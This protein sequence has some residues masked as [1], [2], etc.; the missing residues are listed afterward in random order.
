MHHRNSYDALCCTE[1]M[2][3]NPERE[4]SLL[5]EWT[6]GRPAREAARE[7][8]IPE[9]T[10]YY[11]W[12]KFNRDPEK[13][14]RLARSLKPRKKL[15][16]KDMLL[17]SIEVEN[18]N[19]IQKNF[20][21]L[22]KQGKYPQAE[23]Y[24]RATREA[25]HF[26]NELMAKVNSVTAL[27]MANPEN[28]PLIPFV[29]R[30]MVG[31]MVAEGLSVPEAVERVQQSVLPYLP[32]ERTQKI[33]SMFYL[34]LEEL[35]KEYLAKQESD[36]EGNV[37]EEKTTV[38][39]S[40]RPTSIGELLARGKGKA[41]IP[42]KSM[43][44]DEAMENMVNKN[45]EE[46]EEM[47]REVEAKGQKVMVQ[48]VT[49]TEA[50]TKPQPDSRIPKEGLDPK[51]RKKLEELLDELRASPFANRLRP[52]DVMDPRRSQTKQAPTKRNAPGETTE[53]GSDDEKG[54]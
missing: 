29:V 41:E 42:K 10:T 40:S 7:T 36:K 23:Y 46:L 38:S 4:A 12:R 14:N 3:R 9:G 45:M 51:M 25:L 34:A 30:E 49:F 17:Q 5:E 33:V 15:N 21:E 24:I 52:S 35:K 47:K 44:F 18:A 27:Y 37:E 54:R 28:F 6:K 32:F 19:A 53:P 20:A 13:A 2:K 39:T 8:G 48:E 43:N 11:Y 16:E 26:R 1:L 31:V 22:I 50:P